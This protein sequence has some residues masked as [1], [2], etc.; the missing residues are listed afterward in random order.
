MTKNLRI[1]NLKKKLIFSFFK[2]QSV[3][4]IYFKTSIV[5]SLNGWHFK[6]R[7]KPKN[8]PLN[9]PYFTRASFVYSEQEGTKLQWGFL[10]LF[11]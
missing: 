7:L 3:L 10:G 2:K 6:I 4:M 11:W 8:R 9:R 1:I 5:K